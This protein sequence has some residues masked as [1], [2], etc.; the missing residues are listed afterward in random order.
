MTVPFPT[1]P[2]PMMTRIRAVG[3]GLRALGCLEQR[4]ALLRSE[5]LK[6]AGL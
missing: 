6:T 1:P 3:G 2:G 5:A 4:F